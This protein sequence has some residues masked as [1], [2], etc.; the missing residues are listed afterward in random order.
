LTGLR[1]SWQTW[2]NCGP[3]TLAIYLSYFGAELAPDDLRPLLRTHADDP[4]VT[5]AELAAVARS[6]G[7]AAQVFS[8]GNRER[9]QLLLSNGFPV[10]VENWMEEEPNNGMGHYRLLTGYDDARRSW[11]AYDS[12][13]YHHPRNPN[14]PYQGIELGYDEFDAWWKVF[15]RTYLLVYPEAQTSLVQSLLGEELDPQLMW[16]RALAEAWDAAAQQPADAFAWFNVGT[17]LVALGRYAEAAAVY[18]RAQQLGLPWRMLWY[19][20]GPFQAYYMSGQYATVVT[21]A[22]TTLATTTGDDELYYWRGQGLAALG[23]WASARQAWQGAL[24]LNPQYTQAREALA[25]LGE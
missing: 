19:Q 15:N 12:Y 2:N 21:L 22:D 7:Y 9:L 13:F 23:D 4:N 10:L 20:F 6:Q 8:N 3:T 1:H 16:H 24:A 25:A 5:P 14:G 18:D 17:D 11:S